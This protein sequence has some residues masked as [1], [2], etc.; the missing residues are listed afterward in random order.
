M[1]TTENNLKL[2]I[3]LFEALYIQSFKASDQTTIFEIDNNRLNFHLFVEC[4]KAFNFEILNYKEI[5]N[6]YESGDEEI[7]YQFEVN[8]EYG[9]WM[10]LRERYDSDYKIEF[11]GAYTIEHCIK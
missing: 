2:D 11:K 1:K 7:S 10:Y 5:W 3:Q 4:C 6:K 8:L 9:Y